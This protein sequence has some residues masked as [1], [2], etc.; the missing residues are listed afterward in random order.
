MTNRERF[1]E[2]KENNYCLD[3]QSIKVGRLN[4]NWL[5]QMNP[6]YAITEKDFIARKENKRRELNQLTI[7]K[8]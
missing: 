2:Y 4:I 7:T 6:R 8:Y 3:I 5:I 1:Q